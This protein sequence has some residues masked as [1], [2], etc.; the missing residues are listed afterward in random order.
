MKTVE[1]LERENAALK[2][3]NAAL[4]KQLSG[5]LV[6]HRGGDSGALPPVVT[7]SDAG[8]VW[9]RGYAGGGA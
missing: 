6:S 3:E 9:T 4:K 8:G 1:E 5:W 7:Y 2:R